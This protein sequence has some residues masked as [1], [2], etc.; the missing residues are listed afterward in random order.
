M[1][2]RSGDL[3]E[4]RPRPKKPAYETICSALRSAISTGRLPAGAVLLEGPIAILFGS[5]RTPVKQALAKLER[6]GMVRRFDGRGMLAGKKGPPLRLQ[7][8]LQMLGADAEAASPKAPA[9]R[10]HYYDFE[11]TVVLRA[12]MD[13]ARINEVALARH[14]RVG[15]TVASDLLA[16][17]AHMGIVYRNEKSHWMINPLDEA[18]FRHLYELRLLLEP[19]GLQTAIERI[20]EEVLREARRRLEDVS[21]R[22]PLVESAELDR[23]EVDL[24]VDLIGFSSNLEILEALKRTRCLLVAGKHIQRAVRDGGAIDAF[25]DEHLGIIDAI[26]DKDYRLARRRLHHH[27]LQSSKKAK[28]R[29]QAFRQQYRTAPIP[30]LFE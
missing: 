6:E 12:T 5:S 23:L 16:N 9:W 22:F 3:T 26:S 21:R 11:N 1:A 17:A 10:T 27:L 8:T 28:Q 25:M 15:R 30:F 7:I 20:P 4:F 13:S 14:Y 24:H 18:R 2:D 19:A 29:L